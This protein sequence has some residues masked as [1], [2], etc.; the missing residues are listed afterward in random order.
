MKCKI[1]RNIIKRSLKK[2]SLFKKFP[3]DKNFASVMDKNSH[4]DVDESE[5][6]IILHDGTFANTWDSSSRTSERARS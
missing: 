1:N 5:F 6:E 2:Y 3:L 4:A